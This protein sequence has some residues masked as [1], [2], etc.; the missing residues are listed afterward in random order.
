MKRYILTAAA[1][2]LGCSA[3]AQSISF[4]T[5][6]YKLVGVYD[7]WVKSPFRTGALEPNVGV[8]ENHLKD[9]INS[10]S[11]ILGFSVR[12]MAPTPLVLKSCLMKPGE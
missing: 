4:D 3:Y 5:P 11:H 2:V 1:V 8:V 6:D 7:T 9:S 12:A 10:S